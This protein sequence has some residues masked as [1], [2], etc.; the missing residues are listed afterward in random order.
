M[1]EPTDAGAAQRLA[2]AD[3][4]T[5]RETQAVFAALAAKGHEARAVGGAVRNALLGRPVKDVDI[6]TTARPDEIIAA[7][8]AAGLRAEPTGVAHGT[9]TVVAD[10]VPYQVT[11]LREDVETYGRHATVAFTRDWVQ[12]A[13]RRDFTINA[14]YCSAN[15]ALFDPLGAYADVVAAR[16]RF[17]GDA[18]A[19]IREDYLRILRFFRLTAEYAAG[20]PDAAGLVACVRERQGLALLSAERVREEM[21]RLLAAPRGPELVRTMQDYGLLATVL[22]S[23]PR[24]GLLDRLARIETALGLAPDAI[25]RLGALCVEIAEDAQRLAERLRLSSA[26]RAALERTA[27]RAPDLSPRSSERVAKTYLYAAG[28]AAYRERVLIAWARS[29]AQ[30]SDPDWRARFALPDRWRAPEFPLN[31]ADVLSLG[32]AEGPQVGRLLR[33]VEQWWIANDFAAGKEELRSELR[34]MAGKA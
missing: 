15:G 23:A 24:P 33:A 9:V 7:A 19:R 11:T 27:L 26:E 17:I 28:E 12:D 2:D 30:P 32:V 13:R 20:P 22:G 21:L 5:R 14:L 1:S 4:L 3:W 10:H 18:G 31:G 29:E 8:R 34:K 6:A 16:I 25:L